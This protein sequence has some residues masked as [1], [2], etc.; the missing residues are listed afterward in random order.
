MSQTYEGENVQVSGVSVPMPM[1]DTEI[2]SIAG[3]I[4]EVLLSKPVLLNNPGTQLATSDYYDE[5]SC[6]VTAIETTYNYGRFTQ[7]LQSLAFNSS[8]QLILPN[9]SLTGPWWLH[10]KLPVIPAGSN[11]ILPRGWGYN[12]IQSISY[13]P[14]SSN[15]SQIAVSGETMIMTLLAMCDTREKASELLRLGG[16]EFLGDSNGIAPEAYVM[17]MLPWSR[18][19]GRAESKR[20]F[21]SSLLNSVITVSINTE[22]A[23]SFM[24][25]TDFESYATAFTRGQIYVR[26]GNVTGSSKIDLKRILNAD[27]NRLLSYP[28]THTTDGTVIKFTADS[29][30]R[31]N[32]TLQSFINADLV[33]IIFAVIRDENITAGASGANAIAPLNVVPIQ[34]VVVQYNGTTYYNA[35][36]TSYR[37]WNMMDTTGASGFD[38]SVPAG[39]GGFPYNSDPAECHPII[40]DFSRQRALVH[41]DITYNVWR[42][43][44]NV[45]TL[46]FTVP[47]SSPTDYTL[48]SVYNYNALLTVQS[49]NTF[50][51]TS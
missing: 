40:I 45:I 15:V 25:G 11:V 27:P 21:D 39:G 50:L 20:P 29:T 35:P 14:G 28:F 37:L 18:V 24:S 12:A 42:I 30:N 49:G 32:L 4:D 2:Q 9:Q 47:D 43:A 48:R 3:S 51:Q 36:G 44:N 19:N 33:N 1:T 16:E 23:S 26:Q 46:S 13:L 17:L 31:V 10:L 6:K 8:S 7:G 5:S 22:P 38:Y 41:D 34:D